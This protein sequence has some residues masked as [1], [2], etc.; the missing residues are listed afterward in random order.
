MSENFGFVS[1]R[2]QHIKE[3]GLALQSFGNYEL[4][5][6]IDVGG[7]GE[8]YLAH[9]RSAFGRE[10]AIKIIRSDLVNDAI[11]RQRFV[12]EAEVASYLKHNHI[13]P[14]LEFGEEQGRLFI[15]TPYIKDGTLAQRLQR[16]ALPITEVHH[17]FNALGRAVSYLHKRGIVHRDLKPANILLDKEEDGDR[18]YVRLIDFG[19]AWSQG[20]FNNGPLPTN[21]P[22]FGT[23]D[24]MAP[25]RLQGIAAPSNDIYSLGVILH[26]ML[27]G[28]LPRPEAPQNLPMPLMSVISRCLETEPEDRFAS[29][30]DLLLSFD[31]AFK[32]LT[33][34][35]Q[36][37]PVQAVQPA[38][39]EISRT[40]R[41]GPMLDE[42]DET[43][44]AAERWKEQEKQEPIKPH[45]P[46]PTLRAHQGQQGT[47]PSSRPPARGDAPSRPP[48]RRGS[49]GEH[50]SIPPATKRV[51]RQESGPQRAIPAAH[52]A[53]NMPVIPQTA[54][55]TPAPVPAQQTHGTI[56]PSLSQK[57]TAFKKMDYDAPTTEIDA[58]VSRPRRK[59]LPAKEQRQQVASPTSQSKPPRTRRKRRGSVIAIF[60]GLILAVLLAMAGITYL[61]VQASTTASV[62][63]APRM[64][65]VNGVFTLTAKPGVKTIDA[66]AKV[67]PAN[68]LTSTQQGSMQGRP[69]GVSGC[70]LSIFECKETVS[71]EDVSTLA[72]QVKPGLKYQI[73]QDIN[74][75][76]KLIGGTIVGTIVYSDGTITAN[77]AVGTVSKSMSVTVNEQG[78]VEYFQAKDVQNLALQMLKSKLS[79]NY[80]LIDA[81]TRVGQPVIRSQDAN[82]NITIAIAAAGISRYQITDNIL[83]TLKNQLKGSNLKQAQSIIRQQPNL[84]TA[85]ASVHLSYGDTIPAN[86]QQIHITILNPTAIPAVKLPT[87]PRS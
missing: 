55:L 29:V 48:V 75:Q 73:T 6:R 11:A 25:E 82:G 33:S 14:L 43:E 37:R 18:V 41:N 32:S 21:G 77:P 50:P 40:R 2:K 10:V 69:T 53:N 13:L 57:D 56:L 22:D 86:V 51:L 70:V 5:R 12:R 74:K 67:I 46:P 34:S 49:S 36:M 3:E 16:G 15:V 68:V 87:V 61:I 45:L 81:M 9:Q 44:V 54:R 83:A 38:Q 31:H 4:I 64:Q 28:D 47:E 76:A 23:A 27:T 35:Q 24:Y 66:S 19:I 72:A 8:V 71:L 20:I 63:I 62:L 78:S 58:E 65:T 1:E 42:E 26:L 17:L 85:T 30:D 59:F 79:S 60:G 7:M 39:G 80:D 52:T 84:D